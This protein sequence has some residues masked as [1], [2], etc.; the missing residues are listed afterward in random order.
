MAYTSIKAQCKAKV[1]YSF[2]LLGRRAY[3]NRD[4]I[5]S[6]PYLMT[7]YKSLFDDDCCG[8]DDKPAAPDAAPATEG[9]APAPAAE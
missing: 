2:L 7:S 5:F 9:E 6:H 1:Q 3:K 8:G 4:S